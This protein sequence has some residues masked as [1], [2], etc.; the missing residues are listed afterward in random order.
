MLRKTRLGL[1]LFI[2]QTTRSATVPPGNHA[3][4]I[5]S[6]I[7]SPCWELHTCKV[8]NPQWALQAR[9]SIRRRPLFLVFKLHTFVNNLKSLAHCS[10]FWRGCHFVR[11]IQIKMNSRRLKETHYARSKDCFKHL[12]DLYAH[13][14]VQKLVTSCVCGCLFKLLLFLFGVVVSMLANFY[15][16]VLSFEFL[17]KR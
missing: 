5:G 3:T 16:C 11:I 9:H 2:L 8:Q 7:P 12:Q 15:M 10:L 4:Q 1:K 6:G 14:C 13:T 17:T